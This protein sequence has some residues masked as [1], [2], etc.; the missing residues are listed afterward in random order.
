[1]TDKK[2]WCPVHGLHG[3]WHRRSD[4]LYAGRTCDK[5]FEC[6][7]C[8]TVQFPIAPDVVEAI[9]AEGFHGGLVASALVEEARIRADERSF[10]L[11]T[12]GDIAHDAYRDGDFDS[13]R[14]FEIVRVWLADRVDDQ[15]E[16]REKHDARIRADERR[17]TLEELVFRLDDLVRD[18]IEWD[19]DDVE[20]VW[21]CRNVMLIVDGIAALAQEEPTVCPDH[22]GPC[23]QSCRTVCAKTGEDLP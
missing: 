7:E 5:C 4:G 15:N 21:T 3:E 8:N 12:M 23:N 11:D 22:G 2:H 1:M 9:R 14:C 10:I 20:D 16:D 13:S 17:K 19:E 6:E 18:R